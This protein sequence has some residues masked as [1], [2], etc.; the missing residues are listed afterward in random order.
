MTGNCLLSD[1]QRIMINFMYVT[2]IVYIMNK[3]SS[4]ILVFIYSYLLRKEKGLLFFPLLILSFP[5]AASTLPLANLAAL[6]ID[7]AQWPPNY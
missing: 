4:I 6:G 7:G 3:K 5:G 1:H 2:N